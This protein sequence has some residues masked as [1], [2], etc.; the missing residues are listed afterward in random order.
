MGRAAG[1]VRQRAPAICGLARMETTAAPAVGRRGYRY[2]VLAMLTMTSM[3]SIV[4][5]L[6]LSILLQ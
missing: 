1:L 6:V 2:Y 4:D 3:F 5:R